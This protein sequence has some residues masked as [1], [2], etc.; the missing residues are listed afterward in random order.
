MKN[1]LVEYL[2]EKCVNY[3]FLADGTDDRGIGCAIPAPI[4][5]FPYFAKMFNEREAVQRTE[6]TKEV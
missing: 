6:N 2:T 5:G 3:P 1:C 4:M